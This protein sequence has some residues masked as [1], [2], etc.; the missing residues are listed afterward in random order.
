M[1]DK[2]IEEIFEEKLK[3]TQKEEFG[4]WK[5]LLI[6]IIAMALIYAVALLL[7][8]MYSGYLEN[9]HYYPYIKMKDSG[10]K[11]SY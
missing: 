2:K 4:S 9:K 11:K 1:K 6:I 8:N 5:N 10:Y 3:E 7:W